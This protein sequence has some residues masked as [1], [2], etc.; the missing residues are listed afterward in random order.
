[1]HLYFNFLGPKFPDHICASIFLPEIP[2]FP[3]RG[4]SS[5]QETASSGRPSPVRGRPPLQTRRAE[6]SSRGGGLPRSGLL[7]RGRA[8]KRASAPGSRPP[9]PAS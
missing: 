6:Q 5:A 9:L 2:S 3:P 7:E 4:A 1:M 8:W